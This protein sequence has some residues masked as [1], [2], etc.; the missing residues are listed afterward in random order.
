ML[1][2]RQIISIFK[3]KF[4]L[5]KARIFLTP[6]ITRS[7]A[8]YPRANQFSLITKTLQHVARLTGII[9]L[10]ACLYASAGTNGQELITINMKGAPPEKVFLEIELRSGYSVFYNTEMLKYSGPVTIEMK[11]ATISDV[12]EQ[13]LKGLPLEFNIQDKTIFVKKNYL[14]TKRPSP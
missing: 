12:M 5:S 6:V 10:I 1:R 2:S 14:I 13:C 9:I 4:L 3:G 11:D 8:T 7:A